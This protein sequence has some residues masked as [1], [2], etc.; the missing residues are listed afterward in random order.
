MLI[1]LV[2]EAVADGLVE[3]RDDVA[4]ADAVVT[5]KLCFAPARS[6]IASH[7]PG[8]AA[9]RLGGRCSHED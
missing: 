2:T 8:R 9:Q 1:G 4:V 7:L 5:P 3:A 6:I